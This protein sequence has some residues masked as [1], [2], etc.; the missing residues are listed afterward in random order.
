MVMDTLN[1]N[2][3]HHGGKLDT[4]R[5][6]SSAVATAECVR[7]VNGHRPSRSL[8]DISRTPETIE[9]GR[10]AQIQSP[11]ARSE[12]GTP[13]NDRRRGAVDRAGPLKREGLHVDDSTSWWGDRTLS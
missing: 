12:H 11:Q 7:K 4:I 1:I 2:V 8:G 6:P 3:L 10:H 13:S 9:G 5:P